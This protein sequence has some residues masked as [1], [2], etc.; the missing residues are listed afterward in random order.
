MKI[1]FYNHTGQV[2][3][4]ERVLL[5]ILS[6]LDRG[7]FEP[8][9]ACPGEGRLIGIVRDLGIRTIGLEQLEA[10]FTWRIGRLFRYLASFARVIRN[11]RDLVIDEEPD[12]IHANSIRAG[13]VLSAA[14]FGLA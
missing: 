8:V 12:V 2:S 13:L 11:A 14:S 4:A 6:R 9:V 7:R 5:M 1:L 10:R 3:G